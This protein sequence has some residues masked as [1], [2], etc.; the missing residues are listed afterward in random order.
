MWHRLP[1]VF[2]CSRKREGFGSVEGRRC[3]DFVRLVR[4]DL[5][6]GKET[7]RQNDGLL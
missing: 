6:R 1:G 3:A 5:L 7:G 2:R 4:V